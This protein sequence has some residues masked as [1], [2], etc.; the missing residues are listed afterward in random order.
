MQLL[1]AAVYVAWDEGWW[2]GEMVRIST[3][4]A[5]ELQSFLTDLSTEVRSLCAMYALKRVP[6]VGIYTESQP[7]HGYTSLKGRMAKTYRAMMDEQR[8]RWT[9]DRNPQ[10]TMVTD[11]NLIGKG[12][13]VPSTK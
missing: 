3:G 6:D 7:W 4:T 8:M 5:E 10:V 11:A 12:E 13:P 9:Y 2:T 1:T